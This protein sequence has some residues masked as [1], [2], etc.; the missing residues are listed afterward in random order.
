MSNVLSTENSP[1]MKLF[2]SLLASRYDVSVLSAPVCAILW[3]ADAL[4]TSADVPT[5]KKAL[6]A[7]NRRREKAGV[8]PAYVPYGHPLF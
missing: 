4:A 1:I 5:A 6:V 2:S 7:V 3:T 8:I